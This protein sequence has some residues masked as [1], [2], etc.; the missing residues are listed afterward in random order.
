MP[1]IQFDYLKDPKRQ[2]ATRIQL[3]I[4]AAIPVVVLAMAPLAHYLRT[5]LECLGAIFLVAFFLMPGWVLLLI[6][7]GALLGGGRRG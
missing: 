2:E 3:I 4:L 7:L 1:D 6:V 5:I